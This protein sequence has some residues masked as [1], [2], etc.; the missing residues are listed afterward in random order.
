MEEAIETTGNAVQQ[1]AANADQWVF[2]WDNVINKGI[3][4]GLNLVIA[5]AVL[6]IGM[7]IAKRLS[8][9]ISK[10]L[11]KKEYDESL[12]GFLVSLVSISLRI[13]VVLTTLSQLGVEMTSFVALLGAAGLAI[14]MAFSG[15]LG[16]F[17]GGVMILIFR[18]YKVGD[19]IEAQGEF[20]TVEQI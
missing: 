5:V 20:G 4:Y 10:V 12:Q 8:K 13:L 7:M 17:A 3:E 18:P 15:T 1:G 19:L 9:M 2:S 16:N 6:I 14:G 11:K